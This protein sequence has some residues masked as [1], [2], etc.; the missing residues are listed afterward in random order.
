MDVTF[1][2][3]IDGPCLSLMVPVLSFPL[4]RAQGA[5][6]G[7]QA[8]RVAR[9]GRPRHRRPRAHPLR[10]RPP[11]RPRRLRQGLQ[12]QDAAVRRERAHGASQG[13]GVGVPLP[14][15]REHGELDRLQRDIVAEKSEVRAAR[16]SRACRSSS[17][18]RPRRRRRRTT[19]RRRCWPRRSGCARRRRRGSQVRRRR[20]RRRKRLAFWRNSVHVTNGS[21]ARQARTA[22]WPAARARTERSTS[23]QRPR[24]RPKSPPSGP[25][26]RTTRSRPRVPGAEFWPTAK[27]SFHARYDSPFTTKDP[28][29]HDPQQ[30]QTCDPARRPPNPLARVVRRPAAGPGAI[31]RSAARATCLPML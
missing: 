30:T 10:P 12:P 25:A 14:A 13:H 26:P 20:G 4:P 24:Q 5:P 3:P 28:C 31:R 19:R 29:H 9:R 23:V 21:D 1:V 2:N 7:V 6:P 16:Q 27:K 8:P 17:S 15:V 18:W 11:P 22:R